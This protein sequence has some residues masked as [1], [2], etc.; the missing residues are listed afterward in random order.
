MAQGNVA[1][2]FNAIIYEDFQRRVV[3]ERAADAEEEGC[4]RGARGG[5]ISHQAMEEDTKPP[6]IIMFMCF[7][8]SS[9]KHQWA[10]LETEH[11]HVKR[12]IGN[13]TRLELDLSPRRAS[14][15]LVPS[16]ATTL[17][18]ENAGSTATH[19]WLDARGEVC[20][21]ANLTTRGCRAHIHV[22]IGG[23]WGK[24]YVIETNCPA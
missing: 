18:V 7:S 16:S 13:A 1:T 6:V 12:A 22:R 20:S 3:E 23:V 4:S 14:N 9:P 17:L 19:T 11:M 2:T 10:E 21:V 15:P 8:S 24:E 5:G